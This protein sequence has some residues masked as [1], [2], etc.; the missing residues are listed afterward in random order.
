LQGKL[1]FF[2]GAIAFLLGTEKSPLLF[3]APK[4]NVFAEKGKAMEYLKGWLEKHL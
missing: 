1:P 4:T 2:S 3:A